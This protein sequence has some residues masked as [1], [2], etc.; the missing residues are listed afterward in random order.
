M[1]LREYRFPAI[2]VNLNCILVAIE[3]GFK[4]FVAHVPCAIIFATPD[5]VSKGL[6]FDKYPS[7]GEDVNE[8][9][10]ISWEIV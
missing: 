2:G 3:V 4:C 7:L 9:E 10:N 8:N 5:S 1:I 6:C